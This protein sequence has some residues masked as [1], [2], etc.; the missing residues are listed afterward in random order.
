MTE[1]HAEPRRLEGPES[2]VVGGAGTHCGRSVL[3]M[4]LSR[5]MRVMIEKM[6]VLVVI[7]SLSESARASG[8]KKKKAEKEN[9]T[10]LRLL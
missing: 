6:V 1:R 8:W 2:V 3:M 4:K 5:S 10:K 9:V 7:F